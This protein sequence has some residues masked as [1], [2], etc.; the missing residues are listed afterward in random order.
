MNW[1]VTYEMDYYIFEKEIIFILSI[2]Q[3]GKN[4]NF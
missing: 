1:E 2:A 3:N 4:R